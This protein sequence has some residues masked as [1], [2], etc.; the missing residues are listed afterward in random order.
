MWRRR[1]S[2]WCSSRDGALV[3]DIDLGIP[4]ITDVVEV[5]RSA[6]YTAYRVRDTGSGQHVLVKVVHAADRPASVVERFAREQDV[7][8]ELAG[9]PNLVSV[10]GHGTTAGGDQFVV[11]ELTSGT[12]TAD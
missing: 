6:V 1:H 10:F 9:H 11:T 7:L 4:G 8:V 12:T 3:A 5:G 2:T